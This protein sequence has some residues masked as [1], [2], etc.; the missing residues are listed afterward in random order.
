MESTESVQIYLKKII[1]VLIHIFNCSLSTG[2]VPSKLKPAKVNPVFKSGNKHKFT[3]YRPISILP[4]ISKL[5]EKVVYNQIYDFITNHRIL[6]PNQFGFRK[7]YSTY[8]AMNIFYDIIT[9]AI[10]RTLHTVGIFLDLSKA[11]DTLDHSILLQKLNHYG[12][13]AISNDWIKN[14]LKGRHQFVV[15]DKTSSVTNTIH[16]GDPQGSIL[17]PLLFLVNINGLPKCSSSLDVTLFADDTNIICSNDDPDTLKTVLNKDLY[18]ISNWL[19][20]NKLSLNVTKTNYM[21]FK[22]SILLVLA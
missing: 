15:H 18:I 19:K 7:K 20:L 13:R 4:S 5:L 10:G 8:M 14:Y 9:N 3:N 21:I 22:R 12:I 16:C 17:G 11:F 6:S 1:T 2:I